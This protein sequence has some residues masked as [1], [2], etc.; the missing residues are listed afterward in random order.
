[1]LVGNLGKRYFRGVC[2]G[3]V[4]DGVKGMFTPV[5]GGI[6]G[7]RGFGGFLCSALHVPR[8]FFVPLPN[9]LSGI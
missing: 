4:M 7:G 8:R 2:V 3:N 9:G 5:A 6:G 1:M